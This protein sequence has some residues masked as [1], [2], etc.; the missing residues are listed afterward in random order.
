MSTTTRFETHSRDSSA[1]TR[2][3]GLGILAGIVF[4]L[5]IQFR[6]ER[7][8]AIGAMYTLGEPQ[9]SVGWIAHLVHSALFGAVYGLVVDRRLF[10]DLATRVT[11]GLFLGGG[12]GVALWAVNIVLIWPLWLGAVGVADA[13]SIP[14][15][16]VLPLVG[17]LVYGG[18][19]GLLFGTFDT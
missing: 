9:L 8:T 14:F 6:L 17:H 16:A 10:D 2:G 3:A 18:L 15:L 19:T 1:I 11:T 13:P 7:M 12:Y 5:L 4:G